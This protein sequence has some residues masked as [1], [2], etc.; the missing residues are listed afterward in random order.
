MFSGAIGSY[1][2]Y[3]KSKKIYLKR[4]NL[5]ENLELLNKGKGYVRLL[6]ENIIK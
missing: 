1:K 4:K 5:I 3:I 2:G 6:V